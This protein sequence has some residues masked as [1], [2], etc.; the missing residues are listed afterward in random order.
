MW[1]APGICSIQLARPSARSVPT[2][3][4]RGGRGGASVFDAKQ[5]LEAMAASAAGQ[6]LPI[7]YTRTATAMN[8]MISDPIVHSV[9]LTS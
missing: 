9:A 8:M 7:P 6:S 4:A 3:S 5:T 1:A 2:I